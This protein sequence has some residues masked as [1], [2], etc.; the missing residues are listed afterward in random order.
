[1]TRKIARRP[2]NIRHA[3]RFKRLSQRRLRLRENLRPMGDDEHPRRPSE[4]S[5]VGQRVECRQPGLSQPSRHG[6]EGFGIAIGPDR[7]QRSERFCLP[8]AGRKEDR[9]RGGDRGTR[10]LAIP[11]RPLE[12]CLLRPGCIASDHRGREGRGLGP[13]VVEGCGEIAIERARAR[14]LADEV[15]LDSGLERASG[16]IARPDDDDKSPRGIGDPPRLGMKRFW[17]PGEATELHEARLKRR[18]RQ[19]D[20]A[21]E[22]PQGLRRSDAEV[23]PHEEPHLRAGGKGAEETPADDFEPRRLHE[24]GKQ[25]DRAGAREPVGQARP[26]RPGGA[27]REGQT[28][29]ARG[30][31]VG[32][33][34]ALRGNDVAHAAA[35]IGHVAGIARDHVDVHVRHGLAGGGAT[36]EADVVAVGLRVEPLVEEPLHLGDERHKRPLLFLRAL[37]ERRHDPLRDHEDMPRRYRE[38]VADRE[39]ERIRAEPLR[40][41]NVEERRG[42]ERFHGR[43]CKATPIAM[44]RADE[45]RHRGRDGTARG[46]PAVRTGKLIGRSGA[47]PRRRSR[48][49]ADRTDVLAL[50]SPLKPT[51]N[52]GTSNGTHSGNRCVSATGFTHLGAVGRQPLGSGVP[53][54]M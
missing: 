35:R 13:E 33:I 18:P 22:L 45:T 31:R 27:C 51:Q 21:H 52:A 42:G 20:P 5:S 16:K 23:I 41:G 54:A 28:Q 48:Q 11:R 44:G 36:V 50:T 14:C 12:R 2:G 4:R 17:R 34:V 37:E 29:F 15:P 25:V 53:R 7:G 24:R 9:R 19:I 10:R 39:G 46:K 38:T 47:G 6:H 40:M 49:A 30:R 26:E 8:G 32:K 1:M 43:Q 3:L